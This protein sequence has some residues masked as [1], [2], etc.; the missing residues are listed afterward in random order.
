MGVI[1]YAN[2]ASSR[3]FSVVVLLIIS[4]CTDVQGASCGAPTSWGENL[5]SRILDNFNQWRDSWPQADPLTWDD[6]LASRAQ[7]MSNQCSLTPTQA[8][9]SVGADWAAVTSKFLEEPLELDEERIDVL[10][11]LMYLT[12]LGEPGMSVNKGKAQ[13]STKCDDMIMTKSVERIGCG[14]NQCSS[15]H[16]MVCLTT[17]KL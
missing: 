1:Q 13:C 10:F 5:K 6:D 16:L 9:N 4:Q 2:M 14:W 11:M 15:G 8:C 3:L 12:G 7:Q 17:P